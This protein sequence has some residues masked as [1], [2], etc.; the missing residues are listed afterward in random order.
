MWS[1]LLNDWG[2]PYLYNRERATTGGSLQ[3]SVKEKENPIRLCLRLSLFPIANLLF[4][5]LAL[6]LS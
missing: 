1:E 4:Q 3:I 5:L 2:I 6:G